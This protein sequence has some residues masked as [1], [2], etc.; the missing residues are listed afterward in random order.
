MPAVATTFHAKLV[1]MVSGR[2]G[3][4]SPA[5]SE[6][7]DRTVD[8]DITI[9]EGNV[10]EGEEGRLASLKVKMPEKMSHSEEQAVFWVPVQVSP[11]LHTFHIKYFKNK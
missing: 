7:R 2:A 3:Q 5:V 10:S 1:M 9:R 4:Q 8:T 6:W 11:L